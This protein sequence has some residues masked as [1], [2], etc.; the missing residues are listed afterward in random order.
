MKGKEKNKKLKNKSIKSF[1]NNKE[2]NR[3]KSLKVRSMTGKTWK[4]SRNKYL[5]KLTNSRTRL[6]LTWLII[7]IRLKMKES[8]KMKNKKKK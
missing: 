4:L 5:S 8:D 1:W 7:F 3:N 2:K 6:S